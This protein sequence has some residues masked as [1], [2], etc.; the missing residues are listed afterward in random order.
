MK[1]LLFVDP[2]FKNCKW[3]TIQGET[4]GT[5][6]QKRDYSTKEHHFMAFNL[7]TSESGRYNSVGM[8]HTLR[9]YAIP[10][11]PLLD[12]FY[13]LPDTVEDLREFVNSHASKLD[14]EMREGI[15]FRSQDGVRSFKCV[16]PEYL[17]KYHE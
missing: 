12:D 7:V 10:C 4:Y 8:E 13:T 15:V 17:I 16:S 3:I 5:N 2:E 1:K 11:V 6:I 14:G 9:N